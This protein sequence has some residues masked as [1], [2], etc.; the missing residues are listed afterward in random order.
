M[1]IALDFQALEAK[2]NSLVPYI[3]LDN[4]G[5][6]R[7]SRLVRANTSAST[8]ATDKKG[9][10]IQHAAG[11]RY[12]TIETM[13]TRSSADGSADSSS[14]ARAQD[15][16]DAVEQWPE[17]SSSCWSQLT[18]SYVTPLLRRGA[19]TTL[20]P[21]FLRSVGCPVLALTGSGET[22]VKYAAFAE[23]FR[24]IPNCTHHEFADARHELLCE[25]ADVQIG[26][27]RQIDSFLDGITGK[28]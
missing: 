5:D 23:M 22:I 13:K 3:P 10:S 26:V 12:P 21:A 15:K 24:W 1:Q 17:R 4:S 7:V 20:N 9:I 14:A 27:W 28:G 19:K 25:T 18:F 8:I 2:Q 11:V 6:L 16:P